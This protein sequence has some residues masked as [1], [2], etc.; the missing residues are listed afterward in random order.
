MLM[1]KLTPLE[2]RHKRIRK[3]VIGT[4]DRPRLSLHRSSLNLNVQAVDDF[5]GKTLVSFST[6]SPEFKSKVKTG[7]NV[8]SAKKFGTYV[9]EGLK[10]KGILKI[11]FDRGGFLYHGRIKAFA[12]SLR[13][14]G[15]Q[16]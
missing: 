9:A 4:V 13:E 5:E 11:V 16:F 12:D 8:D 2:K 15:I 14:S 7:G 3:K 10:K 6:L 1:V